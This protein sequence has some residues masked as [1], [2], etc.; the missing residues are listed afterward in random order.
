[1]S[2]CKIIRFFFTH[3]WAICYTDNYSIPTC[4]NL[5]VQPNVAKY[6]ILFVY[7]VVLLDHQ[8]NGVPEAQT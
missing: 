4:L 7:T 8:I 2:F 1:M 6:C 5:D 3:V